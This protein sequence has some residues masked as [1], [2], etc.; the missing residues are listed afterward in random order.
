MVCTET[1]KID[2]LLQMH[3][4]LCTCMVAKLMITRHQTL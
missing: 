1:I 2:I 3:I 4:A